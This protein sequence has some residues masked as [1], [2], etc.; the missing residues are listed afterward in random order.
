MTYIFVQAEVLAALL[1]ALED[2][3]SQ[4]THGARTALGCGGWPHRSPIGLC[5]LRLR[6]RESCDSMV[7]HVSLLSLS[8]ERARV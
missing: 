2:C 3:T 8:A 6:A 4:K 1:H 7:V 5:S